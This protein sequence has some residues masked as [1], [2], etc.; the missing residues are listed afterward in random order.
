M[1]MFTEFHKCSLPLRSL[2]FGTIILLPK[3]NDLKSLP[4][5]SLVVKIATRIIKPTQTVFLPG[6]NIMEGALILHETIHEVLKI[7]IEKAYD[8]VQWDFLQQS[9]RMKDF[10]PMWCSWVHACEQRGNVGI[11][12]NEQIGSYFQTRKG[13]GQGDP[14]SSI[15]FNIVVMKVGPMPKRGRG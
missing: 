14:L 11:K 2:S 1:A 13:L 8:K 12:V 4:R 15:L 10:S 3:G 7:N 5:L 6:R 9:I